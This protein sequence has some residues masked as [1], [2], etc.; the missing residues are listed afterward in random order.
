M[1]CTLEEHRPCL[2]QPLPTQCMAAAHTILDVKCSKLSPPQPGHHAGQTGRSR[3]GSPPLD[4]YRVIRRFCTLRCG[5]SFI[6]A[7]GRLAHHAHSSK[8][9]KHGEIIM[10]LVIGVRTLHWRPN[11]SSA[12]APVQL[13]MRAAHAQPQ[14]GSGSPQCSHTANTADVA[15]SDVVG[16]HLFIAMHT[17][18][19]WQ[20][21]VGI[22]FFHFMF[23]DTLS[24]LCSVLLRARLDIITKSALLVSER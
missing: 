7:L 13:H 23:D 5:G 22:R 10:P 21:V 1:G 24:K 11:Y 19:G 12:A 6:K 14:T 17:M 16:S 15:C 3:A 4:I 9:Y 2:L 20:Y 8:I 18:H